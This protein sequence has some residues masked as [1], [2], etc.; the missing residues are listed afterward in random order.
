LG[1]LCSFHCLHIYQAPGVFEW[2]AQIESNT[3]QVYVKGM[4]LFY[5]PGTWQKNGM[6]KLLRA[7]LGR[8]V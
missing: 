2:H 5:A 3:W 6:H 4:R 7:T 8:Y 1:G